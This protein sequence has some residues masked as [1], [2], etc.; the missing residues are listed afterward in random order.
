VEVVSVNS[1]VAFKGHVG[2]GDPVLVFVDILVLLS[3][4]EFSRDDSRVLLVWLVDS[5]AVVRQVERNDETAVN[6]FRNASVE[7]GSESQDLSLVVKS[8]EEV[9]LWSI[10]DE[11]VNVT[12]GVLFLSHEGVV[13]RNLR[14][15]HSSGSGGANATDIKM[16]A[17]LGLVEILSEFVNT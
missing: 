10:G 16:S 2:R 14:R 11:L 6:V 5:N 15:L 7:T 1:D 8:L 4:E 13:R 12:E 3:L 17:I 9:G